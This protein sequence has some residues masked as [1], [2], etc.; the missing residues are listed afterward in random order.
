MT[1]LCS[2]ISIQINLNINTLWKY[3]EFRIAKTALNRKNNVGGFTLSN[4]KFYYKDTIIKMV[5]Y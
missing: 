4:F 5:W 3:K 1:D 2:N